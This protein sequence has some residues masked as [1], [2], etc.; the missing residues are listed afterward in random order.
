MRSMDKQNNKARFKQCSYLVV[1]WVAWFQQ[2]C[3]SRLELPH[4]GL[5]GLL[6]AVVLEVVVLPTIVDSLAVEVMSVKVLLGFVVEDI[7]QK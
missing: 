1:A 2:P 7:H 5:L 3:Q 6:A 4:R